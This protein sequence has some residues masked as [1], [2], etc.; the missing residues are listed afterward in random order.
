MINSSV[1]NSTKC[2]SGTALLTDAGLLTKAKGLAE[3]CTI[4]ITIHT[5]IIECNP[6]SLQSSQFGCFAYIYSKT[7]PSTEVSA[8]TPKTTEAAEATETGQCLH[9]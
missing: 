9:A 5:I 3:A 7:E 2:N 4:E 6:C 8:E 1:Q